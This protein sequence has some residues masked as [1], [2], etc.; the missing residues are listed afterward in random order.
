MLVNILLL[1]RRGIYFGLK[2]LFF[3]IEEELW[4]GS[5]TSKLKP[6]VNCGPK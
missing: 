5:C 3:V 2:Y 1:E 4:P 6:K